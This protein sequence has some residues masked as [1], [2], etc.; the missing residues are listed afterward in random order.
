MTIDISIL[1]RLKNN[2][3]LLISLDLNDQDLNASDIQELVKNL[4][5]NTYLT[6]LNLRGNSIGE[7][8]AL[9]LSENNTLSSLILTGTQ[10][11]EQ[12]AIALVQHPTLTSLDL[13]QNQIGNAGAIALAKNTTLKVLNLADNQISHV[14]AGAFAENATLTSLNL[15]ENH[16]NDNGTI[17]LAKNKTLLSLNL[18]LNQVSD[19]GAIALAENSTIVS[20]MLHHNKVGV[21]GAKAFSKNM[22]LT[23]LDLSYNQIKPEG[24]S[25]LAKNTVLISLYLRGNVINNFGTTDL[26]KNNTL[27]VLDLSYNQISDAGAIALSENKT[28]VELNLSYNLLEVRCAKILAQHPTLVI[29]SLNYNLLG[30]EGAIALAES[31]TIRSLDLT[32]N[33]IGPQGAAALA[34]NTY[35]TTLLLST[36]F[37]RDEG[38]MALAQNKTLSELFLSYNEISDKGA[39]ALAQNQTLKKLALNYNRIQQE[40]KKALAQNKTLQWLSISD[41]QPPEFTSENLASIFLLSQDLMCIRG[42]NDNIQFLNPAFARVLGYGDDELLTKPLRSLLHPNDRARAMQQLKEEEK[43]FPVLQHSYRYRCKDGSY[44]WIQWSSQLKHDRNYTVG[45]D[46]T[47]QKQVERK[48]IRTERKSAVTSAHMEEAQ[49]F[50]QKQSDFIAHLCH[51]IRNPLSGIYGNVEAIKE[52]FV[53]LKRLLSEQRSLL[54]SSAMDS[55]DRTWDLIDESLKDIEICSEYEEVILNDN[56]DVAKMAE[57]KLQLTNTAFDI[58]N[59]LSE[60]Y[61]ML[62]NKADRKKL[63]LNIVFP[64][65]PLLVKGDNSRLKQ[66]IINLVS[67]AIKFTTEGRIDVSLIIQEQTL[68]HTKLE[69]RVSDTGIG[70]SKEEISKLFKRFSQASVTTSDQY[71]GSG[72]GLLIAKN[73]AILMGGDITIESKKGNGCTFHC[74]IQC[75]NIAYE[76]K[77]EEVVTKPLELT[78][79]LAASSTERLFRK[80]TILVVDDNEINRKILGQVLKR[81]EYEHFFAVD[82]EEAVQQFI[83]QKPDII[84]MDIIMPSVNGIEATQRIRQYEQ[85]KKTPRALII[86]LTGNAL[87]E[88][89]RE[90]LDAGMDDYLTKPCKREV[91]LSRITAWLPLPDPEALTTEVSQASTEPESSTS[92]KLTPSTLLQFERFQSSRRAQEVATVSHRPGVIRPTRE[93][94]FHSIRDKCCF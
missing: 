71:G 35:L 34:L 10:I 63:I 29:L 77:N 40:G 76:E 26:A 55:I 18:S 68:S 42:S 27:R 65:E 87:E 33:Q 4:K 86:G 50:V 11:S 44:R 2:D 75:E 52:H 41:E 17:N 83:I 16:I 12:G 54:P 6:T 79:V 3:H 47:E 7:E 9:F 13:S 15:M 64:K 62:K 91:M 45:T 90:A 51:E 81:A 20:L 38:A 93:S 39:I 31:N 60:I 84:L 1:K 46:I 5:D 19:R 78:P 24:T 32:G 89:K 72:L 14:G 36:N 43:K 85:E 25:F 66:I 92:T 30:D 82:G 94:L 23:T 59:T 53:D 58:K 57:N 70:L 73:L 69:I 49:I 61:R 37:L 88:Q 67:N 8:G 28:L 56:L 74:Y 21:E 22:W 48:L 80:P